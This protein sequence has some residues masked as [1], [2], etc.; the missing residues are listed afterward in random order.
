MSV[1]SIMQDVDKEEI[2]VDMVNGVKDEEKRDMSMDMV[3]GF[4]LGLCA[5]KDIEIKIAGKMNKSK[6]KMKKGKEMEKE[7]KNN[8]S[9]REVWMCKKND[10][11]GWFCQRPV[12]QPNSLCSYHSNRKL[13][14]SSKQRRSKRAYNFGEDVGEGF[15]YYTGFGPSR[16]NRRSISNMPKTPLL[17]EHEQQHAELDEHIDVIPGQA[18]GDGVDGIDYGCRRKENDMS[19]I[20]GL[21]KEISSEEHGAVGCN[22]EPFHGMIKRVSKKRKRKHVNTLSINSISDVM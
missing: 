1:T 8:D 17:A 16:S 21:D 10:G 2:S 6:L 18:H 9:G 11:K 13:Q 15:Y 22:S 4:I 12:S 7:E 19:R 3:N 14:G 5:P 20:A